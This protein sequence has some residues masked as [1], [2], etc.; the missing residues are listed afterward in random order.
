MFLITLCIN[1]GKPYVYCDMKR[2]DNA[3]V[4]RVVS[5]FMEDVD[6]EH[7]NV[8]KRILKYIIWTL[9]FALYFGGS[10]LI[11]RN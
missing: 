10:K 4:M 7:G 1:G 6:R 3:Q 2:P 8:V 5:R 11:V 9:D